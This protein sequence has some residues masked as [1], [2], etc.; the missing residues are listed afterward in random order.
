MKEIRA[1]R[2]VI[3]KDGRTGVIFELNGYYPPETQVL[4]G[5]QPRLV[6]DFPSARISGNIPRNRE[7]EN[8]YIER[9]RIGIHG[10][11]QPKVRVV[12]DFKP[13]ADYAVEQLFYKKE[14]YYTLMVK[15]RE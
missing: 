1:I 6:C 15:P 12:M 11:P 3:T 2:P 8:G 9:I 7:L 5:G 14:N 4:D 10:E 13:G